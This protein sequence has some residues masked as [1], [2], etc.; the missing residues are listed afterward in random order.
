MEKTV[1]AEN[2]QVAID[3]FIK[4]EGRLPKFILMSN[5]DAASLYTIHHRG[6]GD[7]YVNLVDSFVFHYKGLMPRVIRSN[8]IKPGEWLIV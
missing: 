2:L 8:D 4:D 6:V 5:E 1:T 7:E 3:G